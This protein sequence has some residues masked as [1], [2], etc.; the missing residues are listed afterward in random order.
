MTLMTAWIAAWLCLSTLLPGQIDIHAQPLDVPPVIVAGRDWFGK[1]SRLVRPYPQDVTLVKIAFTNRGQVPYTIPAIALEA[2]DKRLAPLPFSW[3]QTRWPAQAATRP[4]TMLDRSTAI[5]YILRTRLDA[6][7]VPPGQT[8]EGFV[9]FE[10]RARTG[11][12]WVGE[13]DIPLET[14][15]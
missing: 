6:E 1:P 3:F 5:A 7:V 4:Q 2:Q 8:V 15:P 9:A 11:R 12:L 14:Q 10:G 13:R